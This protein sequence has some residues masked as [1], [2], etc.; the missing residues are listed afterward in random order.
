MAG[1]R[2]I[3]AGIYVRKRD[4][5]GAPDEEQNIGVRLATRLHLS[6]AP[7][8][9]MRIFGISNHGLALITLLVCTLWGVILMERQANTR[10]ERDYQ[11]LRRS[12]EATPA[13][14]VV[15]SPPFRLDV[16]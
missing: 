4:S 15:P 3:F 6:A 14:T 11:E 2:P 7:G 1:P 5:K 8:T 13:I 9:D 10:A 16:S 12:F